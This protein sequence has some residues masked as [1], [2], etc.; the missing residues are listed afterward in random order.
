MMKKSISL[1]EDDIDGTTVLLTAPTEEL[2][3]KAADSLWEAFC[4]YHNPGFSDPNPPGL[5]E[6]DSE[7]RLGCSFDVSYP[8]KI[9]AEVVEDWLAENS[10][11]HEKDK[12]DLIYLYW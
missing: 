7:G 9:A 5:A 3:R 2:L 10:T 4:Q 1:I 12:T 8:V 11:I 6:F